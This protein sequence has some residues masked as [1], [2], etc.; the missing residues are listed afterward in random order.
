[1]T[2]IIQTTR[3]NSWKDPAIKEFI[4]NCDP[5]NKTLQSER[6]VKSLLLGVPFV[7][8]NLYI[9]YCL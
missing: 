1:M 4:S 7:I 6:D 9:V 3:M 2:K 8:C 5:V